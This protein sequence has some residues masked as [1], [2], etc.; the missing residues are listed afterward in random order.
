[1]STNSLRLFKIELANI[2]SAYS[3]SPYLSC[4]NHHK[5]S[6]LNFPHSL[7]LLADHGASLYGPE[8]HFQGPVRV[9]KFFLCDR[10]F[11]VCVSYQT[12][13]KQISGTV[14]Q[15]WFVASKKK[16]R[17]LIKSTIIHKIE[18]RGNYLLWVLLKRMFCHGISKGSKANPQL[19]ALVSVRT[20]SA[21]SDKILTERGL[22]TKGQVGADPQN[23]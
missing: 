13:L 15:Q 11:H 17:Q 16:K 3:P 23:S 2:K 19:N 18:A 14:L 10:C 8:S 4:G 1:M 20:L 12:W 7:S 9:Q 22:E 6:W 5:G 21:A